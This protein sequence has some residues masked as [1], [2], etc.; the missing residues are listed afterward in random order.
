MDSWK[1]TDSGGN[2]GGKQ[3][4]KAMGRGT[5]TRQ[6]DVLFVFNN[7]GLKRRS[8]KPRPPAGEEFERRRSG[9]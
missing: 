4:S 7:G 8:I 3:K 6:S 2:F 9:L 1:G 5:Q